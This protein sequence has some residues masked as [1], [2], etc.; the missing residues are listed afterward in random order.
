[1]NLKK[2]LSILLI[3]TLVLSSCSKPEEGKKNEETK[4]EETK[5]QEATEKQEEPKKDET[6]QKELSVWTYFGGNEQKVFAELLERYGE[7]NNVKVTSEFIPF[8]DYKK[9]I[10][11]AIAGDNLPDIIMIDNPDHAA[12]A[13]MGVF[14]DISEQMNAWDGKDKYFE[15]PM[16]S[17]MYDGKCYGIPATS[18]CLALIYNKDMLEAKGIT[19]PQTWEELRTAAKELTTDDVYGFGIATPKDETAT[20]QFLPWMI[21]SAGGYDNVNS[22]GTKKAAKFLYD[23][24]QEGSISK[25]AINLGQGDLQKQFTSEK[26][27]MFEGGPWM[28]SSIQEENPELNFGVVKMPKDEKYASVLGGENFAIIAG[29]K[30]FDTAWDFLSWFG[31]FDTMKEFIGQTGYFPP[32]SDVAK[33][34]LWTSDPIKSVFAE[35][36]QYAMPRG[37]HPKWPEISSAIFMALQEGLSGSRDV[38][39]ALD[40]AQKKIDEIMK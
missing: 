21:S 20:F 6:A 18:N 23:M 4:K 7:E 12:F 22:E 31:E 33:D 14:Q 25:E 35:Q 5:K 8:G 17:T 13:S 26:L 37:P 16:Q 28:I 24:M 38:G 32:R 39:E 29:T 40:D 10:S 2:I 3:L 11:V 27:A 30:N 9:Q 1:M 36:M 34:P 15:G 19:P